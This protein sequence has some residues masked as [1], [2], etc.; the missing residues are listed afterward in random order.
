MG[1]GWSQ[2]SKQDKLDVTAFSRLLGIAQPG[3]LPAP[4]LH[5]LSWLA[6]L[7]LFP[8][9]PHCVRVDGELVP[10]HER[11]RDPAKWGRVGIQ[12]VREEEVEEK[13]RARLS[14]SGSCR[15]KLATTCQNNNAYAERLFVPTMAF[16]TLNT[17]SLS[18][19]DRGEH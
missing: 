10:S 15:P 1:Q 13:M 16:S 6:P 9:L 18:P 12:R 11:P 5:P 2:V 7:S 17:L 19:F 8:R 14:T 3:A 4:G